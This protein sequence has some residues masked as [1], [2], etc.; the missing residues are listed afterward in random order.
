MIIK[1][2]NCTS[3]NKVIKAL[4]KAFSEM[5]ES[6]GLNSVEVETARKKAEKQL[7]KIKKN[8]PK[9][10]NKLSDFD[11]IVEIFDAKV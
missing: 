8:Y 9:Y 7:R 3:L 6:E 11:F 4:Y 5:D 10:I 2:K 1:T